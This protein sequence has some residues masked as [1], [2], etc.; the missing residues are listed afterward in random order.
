[1]GSAPLLGQG[2]AHTPVGTVGGV[3]GGHLQGY[4][5]RGLLCPVV[6]EFS[7]WI[8]SKRWEYKRGCRRASG[9]W[10]GVQP[11]WQSQRQGYQQFCADEK[12]TYIIYRV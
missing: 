4:G 12:S 5:E 2:V 9:I 11:L 10:Q 8:Q 3:K 6:F 7:G 1:M